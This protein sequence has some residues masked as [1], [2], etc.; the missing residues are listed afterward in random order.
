MRTLFV[1]LIALSLT[2]CI[3]TTDILKKIRPAE[4][5]SNTDIVIDGTTIGSAP[6]PKMPELPGS[7]AKRAKPLPQMTDRTAAGQQRDAVQTDRQYNA[8]AHQLNNV[9]QAWGCVRE[10]LNEQKDAS[11]CF[12]G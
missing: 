2:G 4:V 8:V 10:A 7:L 3:S 9:I 11:A 12:K 1:L 6:A 5:G